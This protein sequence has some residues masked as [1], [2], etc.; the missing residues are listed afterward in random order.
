MSNAEPLT[1]TLPGDIALDV[2]ASVRGGIYASVD[3]VVRDAM[4]AWQDRKQ[5]QDAIR[6]TLDE[7]DLDPRPS[8]SDEDVGR[9]FD[10]RLTRSL[11]SRE[12]GV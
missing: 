6:G 8:I 4:R 11:A 7:A 9:H 1:V 10:E 5:R 12:G 2:Q 3:D